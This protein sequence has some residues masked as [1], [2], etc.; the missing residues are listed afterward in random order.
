MDYLTAFVT[1]G[2]LCVAAQLVLNLTDLTAA[3]VMVLFVSGGAV[4]S[5]LGWYQPL[6]DFGGAGATVPLTGF[7]HALVTGI[8][9]GLNEEGLTGLFTGGISA[10]SCGI[11]VAVV[12]GYLMAVLFNPKG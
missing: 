8:L 12:F 4:I 10:A 9:K 5:G 7:G 3:H 11:T 6:V 2:L 1:G